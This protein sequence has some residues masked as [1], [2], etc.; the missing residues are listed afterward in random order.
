MLFSSEEKIWFFKTADLFFF[1][2]S[3]ISSNDRSYI[4]SGDH[5]KHKY[6]TLTD[7]FVGRKVLMQV[8]TSFIDSVRTN[9]AISFLSSLQSH[10]EVVSLESQCFIRLPPISFLSFPFILFFV[11]FFCSAF[12]L[13]AR[14][15][16][17][18]CAP[19]VSV[20]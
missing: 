11:A 13:T 12:E 18:C 17:K 5:L 8:L 14:K 16:A 10:K 19:L 9:D 2:H 20:L 3:T 15:G 7:T 1:S 4:R 6:L